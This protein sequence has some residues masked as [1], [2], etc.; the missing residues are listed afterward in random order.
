M[1]RLVTLG[2]MALGLGA[3]PALAEPVDAGERVARLLIEHKL[4]DAGDRLYLLST[5]RTA[6]LVD[7]LTAALLRDKIAVLQDPMTAADGK[8][9]SADEIR[10]LG[11]TLVLGCDWSPDGASVTVRLIESATGRVKAVE[12]VPLEPTIVEP[13]L[14]AATD[15]PLG[16]HALGVGYSYLAGSGVTYQQ[17]FGNGWG[18][19][20]AG[21]PWVSWGTSGA[22]G[23]VNA[24][25]QA[26]RTLYEVPWARLYALA[27]AGVFNAL[28]TTHRTDLG[29]APGLGLDLRVRDSL[30]LTGALGYTFSRTS[31]ADGSNNL[32]LSPGGSIGLMI[33]W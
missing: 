19:Q 16:R 30:Q 28:D 9:P 4:V 12:F 24:G 3:G 18:M 7:R 22:S 17:W 31:Y 20:I 14:A 25:L 26:M 23:F 10:R 13:T 29:L 2:V 21:V 1:R 33:T 8:N 15:H 11:A 32:G 6:S 5:P 27:G